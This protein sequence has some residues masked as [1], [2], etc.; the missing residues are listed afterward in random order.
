MNTGIT[1]GYNGKG[2]LYVFSA[3]NGHLLGD[4][5]N[6][7]EY[8][9]HY[10]VTAVC[11]VNSRGTRAGYSEMGANLWVCAPSND[12]PL[13]VGGVLGILTTENSDRY[14]KDF[15]GTSAAAPIVRSGVNDAALMRSAN[16]DLT[17]RDLKLILAASARK[18]DADS[19]GWEDGARKYRSASNADRYHFNHEYGHSAWLMGRRG[20]AVGALAEGWTNAPALQSSTVNS[21]GTSVLRSPTPRT[22]ATRQP[23]SASLHLKTA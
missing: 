12:R 15:G 20:A 8:V 22:P 21:S 6:L 17:W 13:G 23:L 14:E 19:S 5:S 1:T 9:N 11:S 3:G 10:G 2:T 7:D 18:N 16:S 4:D